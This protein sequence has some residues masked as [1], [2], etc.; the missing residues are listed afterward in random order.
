MV[1]CGAGRAAVCVCPTDGAKQTTKSS[2]VSN[3][4]TWLYENEKI[5]SEGVGSRGVTPC[6]FSFGSFS[7]AR[8]KENERTKLKLKNETYKINTKLKRKMKK[9]NL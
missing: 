8:A 3:F 9:R 2:G 4:C 6:V 7:F 1:T 5:L